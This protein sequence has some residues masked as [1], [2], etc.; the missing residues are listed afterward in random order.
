MLSL[1]ASLLDRLGRPR[2]ARRALFRAGALMKKV[3]DPL[4]RL[5]AAIQRAPTWF[6]AG[7]DPTRLLTGCI[8]RLRH[9]PF[10]TDLLQ[11]AHV[12]RLQSRLYLADRLTGRCLG[13][14]RTFR[15]G[16][17]PP[18]SAFSRTHHQQIDGLIAVL[19][20]EPAAGAT[21]F[22]R[23]ASWYEERNLL[24]YATV[25]WLQ[26]SWA[27]LEFNY[28]EARE[29]ARVAYDHMVTSGFN[30]HEQQKIAERICREAERRSL[31]RDTL[32]RGILASVCSKIDARR[33]PG[34]R[35]V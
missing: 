14:I 29:A 19:S 12:N 34:A 13:E 11:T 5:R 22:R 1:H 10:A 30:S 8:E 7:I 18:T 25:S 21:I 15:A 35:R 16:L 33:A 4:E 24:A 28:D 3:R 6:A 20:G 32:R 26:Y 23:L 31:T 2:E 9:Y 27:T 17:P